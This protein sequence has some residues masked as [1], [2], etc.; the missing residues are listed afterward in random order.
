MTLPVNKV[1]LRLARLGDSDAVVGDVRIT[2][3]QW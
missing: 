3:G 2:G 1:R